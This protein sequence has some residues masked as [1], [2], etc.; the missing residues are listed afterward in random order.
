MHDLV[1]RND[2]IL[3]EEEG[4]GGE[5]N[6][7]A[8]VEKT[9]LPI[10]MKRKRKEDAEDRVDEAFSSVDVLDEALQRGESRGR[11]YKDSHGVVHDDE[12]HSSADDYYSKK[13]QNRPSA[14][15]H[16]HQVPFAKKDEAK[17]EGMRF[18]GQKKK[19]YHTDSNKSKS[20]AFKK[21]QES[22]PPQ[23]GKATGDVYMAHSFKKGDRVRHPKYGEGTVTL[24]DKWTV[25]VTYAHGKEHHHTVESHNGKPHPKAHQSAAHLTKIK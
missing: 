12:G 2:E 21:L 6:V 3:N 19:W 10:D 5:S 8:G 16:Y 24:G 11:F 14:P 13:R 23:Y 4:G 25:N 22:R 17:K 9:E 18:D 7:T 15:R 1:E 20:S